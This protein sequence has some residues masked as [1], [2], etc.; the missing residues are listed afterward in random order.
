[1][2][3]TAVLN[4]PKPAA[5]V[6]AIA[7]S[8]VAGMTGHALFPSPT[9]SLARVTAAA[10][11]TL[12]A[13]VHALSRA[14]GAREARDA[15]L[16]ALFDELRALKSYVQTVANAHPTEAEALILSAGMSLKHPSPRN[17]PIFEAVNG[18]VPGVVLLRAKWAGD[19]ACYRW[20]F[21]LDGV[22]WTDAPQTLQARTTLSGFARGVTYWF[23]LQVMT[24]DG[25]GDFG[26]P[27]SLLVV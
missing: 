8:I 7:R 6:V 20:Q 3:P 15:K 2:K 1:M 18:R 27:V 12:A 16:E 9:P 19:R 22:T 23:R 14:K 10:D 26:D 25:T 5:K 17:K 13:E 24:K 4:L 21:C 11:A